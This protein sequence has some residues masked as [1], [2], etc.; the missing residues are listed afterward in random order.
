M[1]ARTIPRALPAP[2]LVELEP[3][4]KQR[5]RHPDGGSAWQRWQRIH[6][7][8]AAYVRE[9]SAPAPIEELEAGYAA[10]EGKEQLTPAQFRATH[11]LFL[12]LTQKLGE[13]P[14]EAYLATLDARRDDGALQSGSDFGMAV[15]APDQMRTIA[16]ALLEAQRIVVPAAQAVRRQSAAILRGLAG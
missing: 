14:L 15:H 1:T 9:A 16:A 2:E 7:I 4:L 12:K 10:A 3:I 8:C 6:D 5:D 13:L 11:L